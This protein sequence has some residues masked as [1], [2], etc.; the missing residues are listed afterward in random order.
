MNY[1]QMQQRLAVIANGLD[2]ISV[3]G[4]SN[5]INMASAM[6]VIAETRQ[7]IAQILKE[8]EQRRA[9]QVTVEHESEE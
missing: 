5:V 9:Q 4:Y 6:Q 1:T 7:E 8:A 3:K 2:N